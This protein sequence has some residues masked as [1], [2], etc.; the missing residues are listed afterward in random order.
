MTEAVEEKTKVR[1]VRKKVFVEEEVVEQRDPKLYEPVTFVFW[2]EEQRGVP[3]DYEW[4]DRW[5]KPGQCKGKFYDGQ[6]YTLPRIA[7]EYYRDHCSTPIYSNVEQE[8][9]P[10]Q[11]SKASKEIGRKYRFR[12]D[13]VR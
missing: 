6:K 8:L 11:M 9:V 4:I 13:V 3:I 12:L 1:K 2:N 5:M 10:G 7:Y